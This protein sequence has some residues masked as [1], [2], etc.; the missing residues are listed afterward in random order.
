MAPKTLNPPRFT[1]ETLCRDCKG[2]L[3]IQALI[4]SSS[5]RL[6]VVVCECLA[7][8]QSSRSLRH[9]LIGEL[10]TFQPHQKID[11]A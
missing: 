3:T 8:D 4:L 2:A 5:I 6:G 10:A 1:E 9:L 11:L 7:R